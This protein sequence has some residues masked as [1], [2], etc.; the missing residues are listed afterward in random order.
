MIAEN[1]I[2]LEVIRNYPESVKVFAKYGLKC[3]G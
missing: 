3:L 1:T 2:I